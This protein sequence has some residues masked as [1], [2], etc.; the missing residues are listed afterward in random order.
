MCS[1]DLKENNSDVG[2]SGPRN[3]GRDGHL[4]HSCDHFP[5]FWNTFW[6]YSNFINRFPKV[7]LFKRSRMLYWDYAEQRDVDKIMGCSLFIPAA[8]YRQLGGLDNHYF[9]YF[10]ET[11]FCYHVKRAGLRIVYFPEASIVHYGGES[12]QSQNKELV[13]NKTVYSYFFKSQYY[14]YQKNY[15]FLPMLA[16]RFLDGGYGM[17]LLLRNALRGDR[18]KKKYGLC[19]GRA[20]LSGAITV[21]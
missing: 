16:M 5:S 3:V 21:K 11:D 4:Q 10:E 18:E 19:K 8:L 9:M 15:G 6:V 2:I 12:S 13:I 7:R 14:F 1:S 20:F 17:V